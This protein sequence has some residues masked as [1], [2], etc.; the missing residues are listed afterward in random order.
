MPTLIDTLELVKKSHGTNNS[1]DKGGKTPYHW[2]LIRV[3]LRLQSND[4]DLLHIALLH[5]I[6]EDTHVTLED[7]R[8][9]GYSERVIEGVKWSSKNLFPELSFAQWMKAIGEKAPQ[10]T[11]L[12]KIADISDNL[13]F[14][15][16]NGLRLGS[17]N[18]PLII[19]KKKTAT[20]LLRDNIDKK[21]EKKMRLRGEMGVYDRYYK[22]WNLMFENTE[23]LPLIDTVFTGDFCNIEQLVQLS[24]YLNKDELNEYLISNRI[25]TWTITGSIKIIQ[26]SVG[27]DYVAAEIEEKDINIYNQFLNNFIPNNYF[28]NKKNRDNGKYHI[29]II[30]SM[31]YGKLKKNNHEIL[32]EFLEKVLN[33]NFDFYT[34]GIGKA[35]KNNN[36]AYF[37]I[38]ENAEV[39]SLRDK[40]NISPQDFH[41]TLA[42]NEKDVFQVPK[43]KTSVIYNNNIIWT[44][45]VNNLYPTYKKSRP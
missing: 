6:V 27:Q 24:N 15:R 10:D 34:Y 14:E 2:H 25:H 22:G 5:D 30:N 45:F 12:L 38:C 16:M 9:L 13:G 28:N 43:N 39:M 4:E 35:E 36:E 11:I 44:D 8:T 3:M 19:K 7:L 20:P 33:K 17:Y 37:V 1:M 40:L 31:S 32:N 29:T 41:I 42:F 18:K 21:V 23:L 26:D